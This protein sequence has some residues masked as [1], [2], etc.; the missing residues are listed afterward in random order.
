MLKIFDPN[1]KCF[2]KYDAFCS[3]IL[4]YA[5]LRVKLIPI[6]EVRNYRKIVCI[7]SIFENGWWEDA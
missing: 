1:S 5:C 4:N 2:A 6:K 7:K 3:R